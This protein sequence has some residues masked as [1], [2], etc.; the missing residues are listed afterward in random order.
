MLTVQYLVLIHIVVSQ[1]TNNVSVT[2]LWQV[3]TVPPVEETSATAT[4]TT[5]TTAGW[6]SF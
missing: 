3:S 6:F 2:D 1:S 4:S 5:T